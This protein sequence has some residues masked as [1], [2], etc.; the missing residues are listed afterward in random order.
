MWTTLQ[1][2]KTHNLWS[3]L[4]SFPIVCACTFHSNMLC[5]WLNVWSAQYRSDAFFWYPLWISVSKPVEK[6]PAIPAK[7]S[8]AWQGKTHSQC[9]PPPLLIRFY[10]Q[11]ISIPLVL[12]P[13][14]PFSHW[15]S[16]SGRP[17]SSQS[18]SSC[19]SEKGV[20]QRKR[21]HKGEGKDKKTVDDIN[22]DMM[23]V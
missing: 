22:D 2:E 14:F 15:V 16:L 23:G 21:A 12:H 17:I 18:I 19:R 13:F 3:I 5:V 10:F 7:V 6:W 4:A 9:P 8:K 11:S 20:Q 1:K